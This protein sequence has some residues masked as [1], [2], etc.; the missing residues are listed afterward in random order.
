MPLPHVP[1]TFPVLRW[2]A[3]AWFVA[4]LPTYWRVW[5][6]ANFLHLCDVSVLLVCIGLWRGS[7]LLLSMSAVSSIIG[8]LAW[9]LDAGWR[10]FLGHHL[11]GGTEYMWDPAFPL[12]ARLLSLFHGVQPILLLFCTWRAGYDP[13]ALPIQGALTAVLLAAARLTNPALNINFAFRDPVFH[14]SW[15]PPHVHLVVVFLGLFLFCY[16]PIHLLLRRLFP[17]PL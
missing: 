13:R 5:G 16:L 6:A 14:R 15:G 7:A 10:L 17:R 2:V 8:N 1:A 12:F 9:C 11:V 3:L 4:W